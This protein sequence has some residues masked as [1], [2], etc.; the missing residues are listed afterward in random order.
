MT[1]ATQRALN[2]RWL[3]GAAGALL[4]LLLLEWVVRQSGAA[5]AAGAAAEVTHRGM[6]GRLGFYPLWTALAICVG[7]RLGRIVAFLFR[8]KESY[9]DE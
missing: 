9:Y 6:S 5:G 8:R 1:K 3:A 4:V 2:K 7:I